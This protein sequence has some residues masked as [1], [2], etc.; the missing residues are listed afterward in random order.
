MNRAIV[1]PPLGTLERARAMLLSELVVLETAIKAID[2]RD[3]V[4][5]RE[6]HRV[7]VRTTAIARHALDIAITN[8]IAELEH[9]EGGTRA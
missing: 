3:P 1:P 9:P 5:L 8:A 2:A 4:R 7:R 6:A